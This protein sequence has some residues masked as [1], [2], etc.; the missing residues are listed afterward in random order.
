MKKGQVTAVTT[1]LIATLTVVGSI[2]TSTI[3]ANSS[4][5][6]QVSEIKTFSEVNRT[7]INS[8]DKRMDRLEN[9][10]DWLVQKQ[11]GNPESIDKLT[12]NE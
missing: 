9:K 2:F 11:G 12:E 8:T 10:I 4:M 1:L 6:K 5:N 3:T 7:M